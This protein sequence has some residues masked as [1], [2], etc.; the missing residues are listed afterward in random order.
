MKVGL[1]IYRMD[2][3]T[4]NVGLSIYRMDQKTVRVGLSINLSI[5]LIKGL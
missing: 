3:K 2:Q 1:S 5:E 4:V